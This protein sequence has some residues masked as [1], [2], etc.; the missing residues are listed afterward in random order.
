MLGPNTIHLLYV[1]GGIGFQRAVFQIPIIGFDNNP[2]LRIDPDQAATELEQDPRRV[3]DDSPV[4]AERSPSR[5]RS[6]ADW[7]HN[8]SGAVEE[9]SMAVQPEGIA[10]EAVEHL[11]L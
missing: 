9:E 5:E 6:D 10:Q 4:C 8:D 7:S 3:P 2:V 1:G 11:A